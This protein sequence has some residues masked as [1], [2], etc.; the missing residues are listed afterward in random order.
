MA[1]VEPVTVTGVTAARSG[2]RASET[3][4]VQIWAM[5]AAGGL[6]GLV[7]ALAM[8]G[9]L[10]AL[11][12]NAGLPTPSE[13]IGDRLTAFISI[14]QF[15]AL[16]DQFGG[17]SGL[18]RAGAGGVLGG[19]LV[20]GLVAGIAYGGYARQH[21]RAWPL[22]VGVVAGLWLLSVG[23]L[24]PN[25]GTN[26]RGL[27]PD[28]ARV[29]TMFGLAVCYAVYGLVLVGAFHL[30]LGLPY[31]DSARAQ[32]VSTGRR[33][34]LL[35]GAGALVAV[36]AGSLVRQL[37]QRATFGYDGT[38]YRGPDVEPITPNDRFYTV[39]KNI[40][41]PEPSTDVW[42]L[43][44]VGLVDRPR[45]YRFEE[46]AALPSTSQETTLMCISN[47]LGG[48]LMS[49]ANWQ[50]LPLR[51]LLTAAGPRDS[52]SQVIFSAAD[53][54]TVAYP[55]E[56][57]L[58]STTFLAYAMNGS[59]LPPHHGFPARILTPGLFGLNSVK[60]V[61]RVEVVDHHEKGFYE[62]Q[63]WGPSFVIP[64]RSTFF[65]GDFQTPFSA[66][67]V[68][69]IRGN[70]FAGNRGVASVDVSPDG[71]QSWQPARLDYPGTELTWAYW[72]FDWQPQS[73][74]DYLLV[75]RTTDRQGGIQTS[76]YRDTHPEGTTGFP[77]LR[78][79][80]TA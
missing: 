29:A 17:Y 27:P 53:G 42:R 52:A 76:D 22:A 8:T 57:A 9:L 24:W 46:L 74:G 75:A 19:Q 36:A 26:Y 56:K 73:P 1:G 45:T 66:G 70:A 20:V 40:V 25:L 51:D 14:Q 59:P 33:V 13:M 79:S 69:P 44:I 63:G 3:P 60:W 7:G 2:E 23:L 72:T 48:G 64:N 18:K 68:I 62:L 21:R 37:V 65:A 49:N 71:G 43:E 55:L 10:L 80:V 34:V 61:T 28:E 77:S 54:Y 12:V 16:L 67:A 78:V 11:R 4:T 39:T 35:A 41:D 50:G 38:E 30:T 31:G 32:P 15:F 6:A 58:E 5:L 47:Y